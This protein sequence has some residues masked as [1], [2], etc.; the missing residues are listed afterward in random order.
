[1]EI[2]NVILYC[3]VSTEEQ[4]KGSSLNW[5]EDYLRRYCEM[6]HYNVVTVYK[7]DK[8]AKSGFKKRTEFQALMKFC[9]AHKH[10][11]DYVLVYRWDRYSRNLKE[12][13]INLDY[14]E[15]L[16]IEVNSVEQN[17]DFNA[18][19]YITMLSL[20]ISMAQSE[21]TKISRRTKEGIHASLEKGKCTYKAPR[22]Y[23]NRQ[24]DD[25][26]KYVEIDKEKAPII[27]EMFAEVAKG[28]YTPCYIQKLFARRGHYIHKNS[29]LKMLRNRFYVGEIFVPEYKD[30]KIG[31]IPAHY[32]KGL[33]EPMV[34][35]DTFEKVQSIVDKK[36]RPK[37]T[38]RTHPDVFLRQYLRCPQCGATM[39]GSA[40]TG[41]GGKYYYYHCSKDA[42][43]LR[44]RADKANDDFARYLSALIPN[45]AIISLYR[46]VI[47]D[48][49][50]ES[51][52][53]TRSQIAKVEEE[54]LQHEARL[55]A[56]TNKFL[57]DKIDADTYNEVKQRVLVEKQAC[58]TKLDMLKNP[59]CADFEPQIKYA[60]SLINN[61]SHVIKE[62]RLD[63]KRELIGVMFPEKFDFDGKSYRT[64]TYNKVLDL[65]YLQTNE[66]RVQKKRD[67]S[68]FPEKSL[69]VP[70]QG[71]DC[72]TYSYAI[73]YSIWIFPLNP[74]LAKGDFARVLAKGI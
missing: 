46:E 63:T 50:G 53:V 9:K 59:K 45:Y 51:R 4:E 1:M 34:D 2:K 70:P 8:S 33:H 65:I 26:H 11:I 57:D 36:Y 28:V 24:I 40:S 48:I 71:L 67:S 54:I 18:S 23:I 43:H 10:E 72:V 32:V 55:T 37:L 69:Q 22:G 14:F 30:S 61:L 41:N 47:K 31:T 20:Y 25:E 49:Q 74:P 5:Q 15:K 62:G 35:I 60:M 73:V 58:L 66:L 68:D 7:E 3:R 29:F 27:R 6:K 16:G 52:I 56:A 13:L 42:K 38:K 44:C 21:D 39:T 12:A 17:I 19:D 64:N